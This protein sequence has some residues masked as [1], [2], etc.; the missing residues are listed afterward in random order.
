MMRAWLALEDAS[1]P[2]S[3]LNVAETSH[4]YIQPKILHAELMLLAS[5]I[6]TEKRDKILTAK[7]QEKSRFLLCFLKILQTVPPEAFR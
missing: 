1:S 7:T 3:F 4:S 6:G 5:K 2:F